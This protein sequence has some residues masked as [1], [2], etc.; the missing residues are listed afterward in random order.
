[1][2]SGQNATWHL[3]P[4]GDCLKKTKTNKP[5]KKQK[6]RMDGFLLREREKERETSRRKSIAAILEMK[7]E[8]L[9]FVVSVRW[10]GGCGSWWWVLSFS[11][12]VFCCRGGPKRAKMDSTQRPRWSA[13]LGNNWSWS[14]WPFREYEMNSLPPT[15]DSS[16]RCLR[17][18][19]GAFDSLYA[20]DYC[21]CT[22]ATNGHDTKCL[23]VGRNPPGD[24]FW[25]SDG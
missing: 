10:G 2:S 5:K 6:K 17:F 7:S 4:R 18:T 20:L 22:Y 16:C 1:M 23:Q 13:S 15:P 3:V 8:T 24:K 12:R 19:S 25:P 9:G 11:T 21:I 14:R